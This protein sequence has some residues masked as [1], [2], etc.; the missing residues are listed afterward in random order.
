MV[1]RRINHLLAFPPEFP[2]W[3]GAA[4]SATLYVGAMWML[5]TAAVPLA[6][7]LLLTAPWLAYRASLREGT[8]GGRPDVERIREMS[9]PDFSSRLADAFSR[10]GYRLADSVPQASGSGADFVLSRSGKRTVVLCKRWK[11]ARVEAGALDEL[12]AAMD[13]NDAQAGIFV[14]SGTYTAD[15]CAAAIDEEIRL[16]DGA[17]LAGMLAA[18]SPAN[19]R[20]NAVAAVDQRRSAVAAPLAT[21]EPLCPRC[22]GGMVRRRIKDGAKRGS[23]FW[24]CIRGRDCGGI[25]PI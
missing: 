17:A 22:G 11:I 6:C 7:F 25:R 5:P 19:E 3:S 10:E 8:R 24:D 20:D 15:A 12:L 16:V 14:S 1:A 13:A 2:W 4:G 18:A 23:D 9:W 21:S